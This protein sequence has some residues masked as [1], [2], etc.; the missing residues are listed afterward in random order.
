[1]VETDL[2]DYKR[3]RKSHGGTI[4][5]VILATVAGALR[6]W[7]QTRAD[8]VTSRSTVRVLVPVSVRPDPDTEGAADAV[9]LG[10]RVS[11]FLVDL[12]VGE[13]SPA[14]RLHQVSYAM[15]AHQDSGMAVGADALVHL[16]GFAPPTLHSLGARVTN[17]LSK[18]LFNLVVTNVPGPQFP[19]YAGGARMLEAYPVMPLAKGQT[20]SIGVTSYD[21]AVYYGL[22]ADRD[23]MPDV[24]VLADCLVEALAELGAAATRRP[25][26]GGAGRDGTA[27][28]TP[29][30]E[31]VS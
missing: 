12:P 13:P 22:N 28:A 26:R 3:V 21:G 5:D 25:R 20:V 16:S 2:D 23:A 15:Q 4:N 6:A 27:A 9:P 1:M 8:A 19:L 17:S 31:T 24:D 7:L 30:P 10:N 18:R 14:V 11:S 29:V